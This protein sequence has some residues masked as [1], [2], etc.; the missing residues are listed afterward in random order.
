MYV[1]GAVRSALQRKYGIRPKFDALPG[2]VAAVFVRQGTPAQ[3]AGMS[4][5]CQ[6]GAALANA[7]AELFDVGSPGLHDPKQLV[8][9]ACPHGCMSDHG[10]EGVESRQR[11][12]LEVQGAGQFGVA[13]AG[14]L[15]RR[16]FQGLGP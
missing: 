4:H 15:L 3:A 12:D 2:A 8:I 7:V 11:L 14:R 6:P 10:L 5:P 16:Q 1:C 13:D 9:F